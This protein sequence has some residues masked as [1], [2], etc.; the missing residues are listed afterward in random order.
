M[1]ATVTVMATK[2]AMATVK[3]EK[4][5]G[6]ATATARAA[7]AMVTMVAGYKE[8]DCNSGKSDGNADEGGGQATAMRAKATAM[9]AVAMVTGVEWNKGICGWIIQRAVRKQ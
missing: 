3:S 4:G 1:T 5:G 2:R 7:R 9:R 6:R 8:S